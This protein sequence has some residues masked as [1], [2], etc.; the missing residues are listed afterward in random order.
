M[1]K[2]NN[3][4][5]NM[6][7][8]EIPATLE[9]HLFY[10]IRLD[11]EQKAYRD[12]IWSRE[13]NLLFV[14]S[15]AGTGKTLITVATANLMV[16][17]GIFDKIVYITFAG[18]NEKELGYL[19]GTYQDKALPY[20]RP[21]F[22]A[23]ETID[24]DYLK[25]CD[26]DGEPDK[27]GEKYVYPTTSTYM[28]GINIHNAFVICDEAENAT[29][30]TLSKVLSRI[31]DDCMCCVIGHTGQIDFAD[32]RKSGFA[33]CIDFHKKYNPEM[34]GVYE[35]KTNHRGWI[36]E[37]ADLMLEEYE[38]P[39]YGFIYM[40]RNNVTGKLYIGQ[41]K[42]TMNPKDINDEWYLGSGKILKR[43][44]VKYGLDN[45]T[46]EIIYE[47]N[48][49]SELNYM[50][51]IFIQYYNA[52]DDDNFY[53]LV[54]GGALVG[55]KVFN[56]EQREHMRKPH[57]P[58]DDETKKRW[59]EAHRNRLTNEG[60]EKLRQNAIKN[61]TGYVHSDESRKN[62]SEGHIGSKSM[63]KNGI[64]KNVRSALIDEYLAD[65]WIFKSS[66]RPS[67]GVRCTNILTNEVFK[68]E[69]VKEA[70]KMLDIPDATVR[71]ALQRSKICRDIYKFEWIQ[72]DED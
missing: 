18:N 60:R 61:L 32:K 22:D 70:A 55:P 45:F 19:K 43:A 53:N 9:N 67:R 56:E 20:F 42:R 66:P 48:S 21:L 49:Q 63:Y 51:D 41:H 69:N 52:V 72:K 14:N 34:C 46:R 47:C 3:S 64:Y 5:A 58:M 44:I 38:E 2:K 30:E 13:K 68:Y 12:A 15:I 50:E 57:K 8:K 6:E 29:L 10:G 54:A 4:S 25:I 17:Y 7:K 23:L 37:F 1:A 71:S 27:Y 35:L 33:A 39:C 40:T 31:S 24:E 36:S 62:I 11:D 65:G 28:R 26:L 59:V 16:K